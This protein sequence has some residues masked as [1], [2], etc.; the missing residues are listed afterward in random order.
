MIKGKKLVDAT[1]TW[2]NGYLEITRWWRENIEG[3]VEVTTISFNKKTGERKEYQK[4]VTVK[5]SRENMNGFNLQKRKEV[6][7]RSGSRSRKW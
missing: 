7:A 4:Y 5:E 1:V 2:T 3:M 6:K